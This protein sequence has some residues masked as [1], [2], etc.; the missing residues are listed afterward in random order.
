MANTKTGSVAPDEPEP[1]PYTCPFTIVVDRREQRPYLFEGLTTNADKGSRPM[2][3]PLRFDTLTTGDYSIFG[4]PMIAVERKTKQDLYASIS[5]KRDNFE[6]RLRRLCL[7]H[8]VAAIVI[9]A[10]W[11]ELL[12]APPD[13]TKFSPKALSRTIMAWMIRWPRVHWVPMASRTHAESWT[14]RFLERFWYAY[15]E[16]KWFDHE[17]YQES[18]GAESLGGPPPFP[19]A[20]VPEV[21]GQDIRIEDL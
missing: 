3:V 2:R 21:F 18:L 12:S 19:V 1:E 11:S 13:F 5:Q 16:G 9:E 17:R 7:D 4:L 10:E 6:E 8:A 14:F 15:Q 20:T